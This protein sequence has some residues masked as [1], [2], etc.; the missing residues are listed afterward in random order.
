MRAD[1]KSVLQGYLYVEFV[2][3]R[4]ERFLHLCIN[5]GMTLWDLDVS[6]NG[7]FCCYM[8]IPDFLKLRPICRKTHTRVLI[9]KRYGWPVIYKKYK[10]RLFFVL[11]FGVMIALVWQ[12]TLYVWNVEVI[13][14]SYISNENIVH[15]LDENHIG[16]GTKIA[17][18]DTD[19]L[20]LALR[21]N[22]SQIIWS[23]AYVD[24]TSLV[25]HVKERIKNEEKTVSTDAKTAGVDLIAQKNARIASIVTRKGT[26]CVVAGDEVHTGDV[27]V[28][29][30]VDI[31]DD[32]G[33][34]SESIYQ[35]ADADVMGYVTYVYG[36]D[37]HMDQVIA[38]NTQAEKEVA[39]ISV[40]GNR[41]RF[42]NIK[43]LYEEYYCLET[44]HQMKLFDNFYLPVF[45]GTQKY[46]KR[47]TGYYRM[48]K[49]KAKVIAGEH[50]QNFLSELEENGV[51]IID[52]N[53]MMIEADNCYEVS[54]TVY[55]LE[56]I[57]IEN[58]VELPPLQEEETQ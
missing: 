26:P 28:S 4:L 58:T 5:R 32:S 41:F 8:R 14:N 43:P 31:L 51:S 44:Y 53:V 46:V 7:G 6:P 23:S 33:E 17:K 18:I 30:K 15:F 45:W 9:R 1:T 40:M 25:I 56:P 21:E 42:P 12:C 37:I 22:Y 34:V 39:F 3:N 2:G 50:F 47:E 49:E 29:S 13:G 10:N 20:E 27:L 38:V 11:F 36:E 57:G 52:K 19:A 35:H 24:G 48:A 55:A 54:G 16:Y